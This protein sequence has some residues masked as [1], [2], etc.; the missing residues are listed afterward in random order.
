M[1]IIDRI[2]M[3]LSQTVQN[4]VESNRKCAQLNRLNLVIKN[5]MQVLDRAYI[6][7]GKHYYKSLSGDKDIEDVDISQLSKTI[8]TA[9][10]KLKKAQE[11]YVYIEQ[12]GMPDEDKP[13]AEIVQTPVQEEI[14]ECDY[15]DEDITICC[16]EESETKTET[17]TE[18]QSK[19]KTE[20][21]TEAAEISKEKAP[22]SS[23]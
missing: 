2:G 15:D 6:A 1:N 16:A 20:V 11:R 3:G 7:L 23:K 19:Q 14:H 5:E 21:K 17:Q 4:I 18:E 8:E 13:Q 9:K 10:L 12:Y 22:E